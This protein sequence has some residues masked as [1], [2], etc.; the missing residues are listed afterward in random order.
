MLLKPR[1]FAERNPFP[2]RAAVI[3]AALLLTGVLG[4]AWMPAVAVAGSEADSLQR[5]I[6]IAI[7]QDP[8][9]TGSMSTEA[10]LENEAIASA[11]LPDPQVSL[12]AGNLP[13]DTFD[14]NQEGMTQFSV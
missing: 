8:W 4:V 12:K 5:A 1:C 3:K 14:L 9:L 10:A 6:Q 13:V 2:W 7:D 11:Q